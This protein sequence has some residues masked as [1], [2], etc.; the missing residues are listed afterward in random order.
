MNKCVAPESKRMNADFPST[1]SVPK[2]MSLF[3]VTSTTPFNAKTLASTV[4]LDFN[5]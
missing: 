2:T 5:R 1:R 4:L 3:F